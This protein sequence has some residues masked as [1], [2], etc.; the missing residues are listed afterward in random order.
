MLSGGSLQRKGGGEAF[1]PFLAAAMMELA[2]YD[3]ACNLCT[4]RVW[5][6]AAASAACFFCRIMVQYRIRSQKCVNLP[7][8]SFQGAH[9]SQPANSLLQDE[10]LLDRGKAGESC[11]QG[12]GERWK[13]RACRGL[14]S[15]DANLVPAK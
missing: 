5:K 1:D 3:G 6:D 8:K 9:K 14:S 15:W 2:I 7:R 11:D 12:I 10:D 4:V 13:R